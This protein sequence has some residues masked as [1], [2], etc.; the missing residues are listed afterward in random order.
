M[1]AVAVAFADARDNGHLYRAGDTY[2]RVG[3]EADPKRVL[4]LSSHTNRL[5]TPLIV[6][7][8]EQPKDTP[9]RGRKKRGNG[10]DDGDLRVPEK[11]V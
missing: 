11:L 5:G 4:E 10:D 1:W 8:A 2:P 7:A 6:R 3:Y 9:K